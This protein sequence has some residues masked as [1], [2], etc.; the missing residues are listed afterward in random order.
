M[1]KHIQLTNFGKHRDLQLDLG[2]GLTAVKALNEGGKSTLL[3][4]I[5]YALFGTKALPDPLDATVTWGEPVN[6]LKVALT[7]EVAGTTYTIARTKGSAELRY[8]D[9]SVTGQGETAKFISDLLGA[10]AALAANL[11]IASQGE[12]R[13]ALSAGPRGAVQLIEKL[14]DFDQLDQLIDLLQSHLT[15]GSTAPAKAALEQAQAV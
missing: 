7:F 10:D 1:L 8:G 12:I 3:K 2:A 13:G 11:I 6:S 14:A 4:A 5:A 9:E 15:L